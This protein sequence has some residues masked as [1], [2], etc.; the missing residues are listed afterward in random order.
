MPLRVCAVTDDTDGRQT[1]TTSTIESDVP[2]FGKQ[3]RFESQIG[4]NNEGIV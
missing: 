1:P 4:R 2:I 3:N